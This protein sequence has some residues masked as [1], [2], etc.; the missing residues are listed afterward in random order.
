M[1]KKLTQEEFVERSQRVHGCKYD[2]SKAEYKTNNG[3]VCIICTQHG[4]FWQRAADHMIGRGCKICSN[5]FVDTSIFIE[6]ARCKYG[7]KY[8]YSKVNYVDEKTKVVVICPEH[9]EFLVSPNSHLNGVECHI[10]KR[11]QNNHILCGVGICDVEGDS[12]SMAYRKW[13]SMI[14]RCYDINVQYKH[15]TYKGCFVCDDW[16]LYSNFKSW[17]EDPQNGYQKGLQL[18]KDILIKGNK[19]YAPDKCCF[20]PQRINSMVCKSRK[21]VLG[22]STNKNGLIIAT[23]VMQGKSYHIGTYKTVEDAFIAYKK[24]KEKHIREVA[25]ECFCD[26]E[27]TEIVYNALMNYE[28]EITD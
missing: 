4:E 3:K 16:H 14:K 2:Y 6:K 10:C 21:G 25:S 15:P 9:G 7:N 1:P 26:G 20:V 18:D 5:N 11:I 28:V 22:V 24:E 12:K 19:E 8:D 23:M 27:I 13:Q 17:F